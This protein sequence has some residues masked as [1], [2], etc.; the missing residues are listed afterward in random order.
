[1]NGFSMFRY[2]G[3]LLIP[4]AMHFFSLSIELFSK[5]AVS[6]KTGANAKLQAKSYRLL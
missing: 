2:M 1:M 3:E 6:R 4:K 5:A